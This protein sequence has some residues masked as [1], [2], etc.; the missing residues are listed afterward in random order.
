MSHV[1]LTRSNSATC[2]VVSRYQ[3]VDLFTSPRGR[4]DR[5]HQSACD[6]EAASDDRPSVS[7]QRSEVRRMCRRI[8]S[9]CAYNL[10]LYF[11][12]SIFHSFRFS[13]FKSLPL[14]RVIGIVAPEKFCPAISP[15]SLNVARASLGTTTQR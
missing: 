12:K 2:F 11:A 13:I 7:G 1:I 3:L 6:F 10:S 5:F 15:S 9:V 8:L 4:E 14:D